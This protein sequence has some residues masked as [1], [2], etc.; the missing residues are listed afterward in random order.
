[1]PKNKSK[2]LR[3]TQKEL[4]KQKR[5]TEKYIWNLCRLITLKTYGNK[6]LICGCTTKPLDVHHLI[7]R[8]NYILKYDPKNLVPLCKSCHKF[9]KAISAHKNS[10]GFILF[11]QKHYPNINLEELQNKSTVLIDLNLETLNTILKE[12]EGVYNAL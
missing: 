1:M 5:K 8:E 3:V 12:L 11:L 6:C 9:S 4:R 10:I 7:P 2:V